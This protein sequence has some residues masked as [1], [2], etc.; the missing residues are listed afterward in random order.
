MTLRAVMFGLLLVWSVSARAD[1]PTAPLE[2]AK[3]ELQALRKDEKAA[4]AGA[5]DASLKDGLPQ[6]HSPTPGAMPLELP[7]QKTPQSEMKK[8]RDA[9]KNWLLDGVERLDAEARSRTNGQGRTPRDKSERDEEDGS[10]SEGD[11][12]LR[13][14]A[15]Q[16]KKDGDAKNLRDA[17]KK[18]DVLSQN[19]AFAPFLQD[20][21]ADSPVRGKFF[22]DFLKNPGSRLGELSLR[23]GPAGAV[24]NSSS[25]GLTVTISS[26]GRAPTTGAEI[27]GPKPNPYLEALTLGEMRG[28]TVA[29]KAAEPGS[30]FPES[31]ATVPAVELP[32]PARNGDRKAPPSPFDN[33]GFFRKKN[34]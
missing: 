31:K 5:M 12:L 16:K 2:N 15:E 27:G 20:W 14:Y 30:K 8:K 21:L 19:D 32:L 22:D 26:G 7:Q 28:A 24:E 4:K 9:Q 25:S 13:V 23:E 33:S 1:E 6:F 10:S 34:F 3:A 29:A 18:K 17:E 11:T